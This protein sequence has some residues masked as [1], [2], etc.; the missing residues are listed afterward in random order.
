MTSPEAATIQNL[1]S[2]LARQISRHVERQGDRQL[3]AAKKLGIPQPTL[4]K[5]MNGRVEEL[6]LEL[7]IRITVRAGLPVVLQTGKDPAE[8]GAFASSVAAPERTRQSKVAD[9]A[10]AQLTQSVRHLT[11]EQRLEAHLRH[12]QLVTALHDAGRAERKSRAV[13]SGNRRR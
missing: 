12:S 11:P 1:R 3:T 13:P 9:E 6:S 8:A 10:R 7:L 5:I 4:S 2:D